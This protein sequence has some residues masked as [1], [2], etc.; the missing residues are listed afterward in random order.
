MKLFVAMPFSEEFEPIYSAIKGAAAS[1]GIQTLRADEG[2]APGPIINQITKGI[3]EAEFVIADVSSRNPNV[4]YEVGIAHCSLKPTLLVARKD[5]LDNLPFDI[6]HNRVIS[7]D[8]EEPSNLEHKLVR[9]L[10][11][12]KSHHGKQGEP[13]SEEA[14]FGA[15]SDGKDSGAEAIKRYVAEIEV[16]YDLTQARVLKSHHSKKDGWV[17]TVE[18]AFGERVVFTVDVNGRIWKKQRL[19]R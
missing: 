3:D 6:R 5:A 2:T 16:E 4:Y 17:I 7:Y 14:F 18:D 13:P 9:H 19:H 10:Q 15:L 12:L 11:Y 1:T 8:G